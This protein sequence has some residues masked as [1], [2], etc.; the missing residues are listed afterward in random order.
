MTSSFSEITR[1]LRSST[2][3]EGQCWAISPM[4]PC[5]GRR[6]CDPHR[7]QTVGAALGLQ[8]LG[9]VGVVVAILTDLGG[10]VLRPR[11]RV[12][13]GDQDRVAILTDPAG[14]CYSKTSSGVVSSSVGLRSSPTPEGRCCGR[15]VIP[16]LVTWV[17]LRSSPTPEGRCCARPREGRSSRCSGCDPHRPRK[18]GA[19]RGDVRPVRAVEHAVA[20]LTDPRGSVLSRSRPRG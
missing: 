3:R 4:S 1:K 10:S 12:H 2:T 7:P 19:V 11:G 6:C 9:D 20:I 14:R 8:H 15:Q 13:R 18:V 5:S 16:S 17:P